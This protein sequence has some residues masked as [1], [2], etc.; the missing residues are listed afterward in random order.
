MS[1]VL[2]LPTSSQTHPPRRR[3]LGSSGYW[4]CQAIGWGGVL[5][6]TLAPLFLFEPKDDKERLMLGLAQFNAWSLCLL[7]LLGVHLLRVVTLRLLRRK[8][9]LSAFSLFAL[10]WVLAVVALQTFWFQAAL[11]FRALALPNLPTE[12]SLAWTSYDFFDD[13]TLFLALDVI[14]LGFYLGVRT[15]R[16]HQQSRLDEARLLAAARE[17][18]LRAL[19]S[20]INPHFLF[21][22]L[23]SL[24]AL[25]PL[26]QVRPREAI[27][28][29][30]ELLRAALASGHEPLVPLEHELQTVDNYLAL[31][32]LR[33]EERLRWRIDAPTSAAS[34]RVPPFLLQ[35]L[36]ENAVKHGIDRREAGGEILVEILPGAAGL[37]LRVTNPGRLGGVAAASASTGVGLANTR[38]R[39]TLLFGP[40]AS[41]S[42][43]DVGSN[44]VVAEVFMP[45]ATTVPASAPAAPSSDLSPTA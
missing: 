4:A 16:R 31:E 45:T 9:V 11:R 23:N 10:P 28:R 2:D 24:R 15:Y 5:A 29:L 36:V 30:A 7:G 25:L 3:W 44:T 19:R 6:A 38:A 35:G 43:A 14:W 18:E 13:Y 21:N 26:D 22:S 41:F 32:Q 12:A 42:L 20:Q 34:V 27:T 8:R 39:L 17:A 37:R 40:A 1:I 33:H